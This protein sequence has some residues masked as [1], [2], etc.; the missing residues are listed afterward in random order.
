MKGKIRRSRFLAIVTIFA[1][2]NVICDSFMGIPQ[3][4]EGVWYSWIFIMETLT[5]IVLGPYA[6][7]LDAMPENMG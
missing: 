5:G 2:L 6:R 1:S 7:F 4:T 3:F